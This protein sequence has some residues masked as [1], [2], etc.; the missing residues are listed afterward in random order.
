MGRS[1]R[2]EKFYGGIGTVEGARKIEGIHGERIEEIRSQCS[3]HMNP[4]ASLR[5]L[6]ICSN[7]VGIKNLSVHQ[8]EIYNF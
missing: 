1:V 8:M 4:E 3:Q 7:M 2:S 6:F 5:S